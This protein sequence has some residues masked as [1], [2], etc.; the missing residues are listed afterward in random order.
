[1]RRAGALRWE[2]ERSEIH[3]LILYKA[4]DFAKGSTHPTGCKQSSKLLSETGA[5]STAYRVCDFASRRSCSA[6]IIFSSQWAR[7]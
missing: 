5:R 7:L 3:L 2:E 1:M 4:M 6:W